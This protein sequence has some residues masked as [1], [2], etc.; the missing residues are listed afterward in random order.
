M[1]IEDLKKQKL[2]HQQQVGVKY[3]DD[4]QKRIPREEMDEHCELIK[5]TIKKIDP[6]IKVKCC[7]S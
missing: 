7:G 1:T 3:F 6:K 4:I 5:S 2:T